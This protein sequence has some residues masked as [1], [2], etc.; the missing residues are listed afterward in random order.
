MRNARGSSLVEV[1]ISILMLALLA[2]PIMS[3]ALSGHMAA[4]RADRRIAAAAAVRRLSEHLKAFVTADKTVVRGPG[5][6]D[7]GWHLPGDGGLRGALDAGHHE[8]DPAQ[9][10]PTTLTAYGG[11]LSYDVTPRMTPSGIQPDVSF[12]VSWDE[13]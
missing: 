4:G 13:P 10:L 7:D 9:W 6:G 2:T 3:V 5:G 11:R 12:S 8:L 1:I